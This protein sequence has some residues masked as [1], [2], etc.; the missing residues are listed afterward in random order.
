MIFRQV[1]LASRRKQLFL[2][3]LPETGQ[4]QQEQRKPTETSCFTDTGK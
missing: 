3:N 1:W 2:L 4:N